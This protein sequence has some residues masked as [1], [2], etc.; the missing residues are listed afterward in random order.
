MIWESSYWKEDLLRH[1][2]AL[3]KRTLQHRWPERSFARL[4]QTVM[5]GF[6]FIRKLLEAKKLTI[7]VSEKQLPVIIFPSLG[8]PVTLLSWHHL[9]RLYDFDHP[10]EKKRSIQ[11]LCNQVVHSYVFTPTFAEP[12][13]LAG[14][15]LNS[16]RTRNKALYLINIE[17]VISLF[18]SVGANNANYAEK[19]RL[20]PKKGDFEVVLRNISESEGDFNF[21]LREGGQ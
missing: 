9:D 14:L 7:D 11:W 13:G 2:A 12:S 19:F 16:D 21:R 15:L 20:D 6:Y 17:D 8:K 10:N 4:E 3:R 18:E 5:L 1:A